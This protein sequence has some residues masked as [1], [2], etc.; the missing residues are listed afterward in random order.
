[1]VVALA[2]S[3]KKIENLMRNQL[4]M[5]A[6]NKIKSIKKKYRYIFVLNLIHQLHHTHTNISSFYRQKVKKKK[7]L[8]E[9]AKMILDSPSE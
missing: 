8:K 2:Q 7:N 5:T 6:I 9:K 3:K 1:M 4:N